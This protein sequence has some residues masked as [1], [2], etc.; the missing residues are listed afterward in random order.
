MARDTSVQVSDTHG[1][2]FCANVPARHW[3][4][5]GRRIIRFRDNRG[6]FAGGLSE[7]R[8][9]LMRDGS[10]LFKTRGRNPQIQPTD[11]QNVRITIGVGAQCSQATASLY[12]HRTG[13]VF[14]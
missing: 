11:G 3:R 12:T 2:L 6:T 7:G 13:L 5:S 8:F 4:R 9:T 1:Q 10:V 14:P